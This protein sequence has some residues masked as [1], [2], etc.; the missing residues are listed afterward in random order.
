MRI[1]CING[2][3]KFYPTT[4]AELRRF[5]DKYGVDLVQCEDYFTFAVLAA[6][7]NYSIKGQLYSG[8][9]PALA[10]WAGK[11]E[12]VLAANGLTYDQARKALSLTTSPSLFTKKMDYSFSNYIVMS[13][14]PQAFF[15]DNGGIITGFYGWVDID[16]MKFNIERF[17]YAEVD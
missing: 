3:Y 1:V 14:L 2:F 15:Y 8:I 7:P 16:V 12:E 13:S 9:I 11:R 17:F 5:V 6:L 10:T 4:I